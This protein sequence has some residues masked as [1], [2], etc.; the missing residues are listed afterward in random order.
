MGLSFEEGKEMG[1][2]KLL[3]LMS[4][5]PISRKEIQSGGTPVELSLQS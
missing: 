4:Q 2:M 1:H 5:E 3:N